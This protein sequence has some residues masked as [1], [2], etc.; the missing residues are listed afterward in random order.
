MATIQASDVLPVRSRI[1]WGAVLAGAFIA[2][3]TYLV[4]TMLGLAMGLSLSNRMS[5]HSLVVAAGI[6]AIASMLVAL[7]VG[8]CVC[9]RCTAGENKVEA[10]MVGIVVWGVFFVLL[11]WLSAGA[12]NTGLRAVF[13]VSETATRASND[14]NPLSEQSLRDA[15]FTERQIADMRAQF[16]KLRGRASNLSDEDRETAHR[17]ATAAAWWTLTGIILSL[18]AAVVGGL[19]GAGPTLVLTSLRLRSPI[20]TNRG[21]LQEPVVR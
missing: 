5:S 20:T 12:L 3:T 19:V 1:S 13:G 6:W 15:G 16:D 4:L 21:V 8:G 17:N 14:G 18:A 11:A 2:L 7:F 9:S 10:A